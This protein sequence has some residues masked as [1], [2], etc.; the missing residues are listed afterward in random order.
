MATTRRGYSEARWS[1][2]PNVAGAVTRML[3]YA[4]LIFF[5]LV[6]L[7][8][9]FWVIASS[10][11]SNRELAIN[12]LGLPVSYQWDNY[13]DAWTRGRFGKYFLN[14]VIV[15]LPTVIGSVLLAALGG[16]GFARFRLRGGQ[17]LFYVFLLGLMVP[18]QSIMI[19]LF[20]ILRDLK[21]LGTY[22][23]FIIP[24]I[25]LGLPFGIFFMRAFFIR[26]PQELA[27]AAKIDGASELQVFWRIML[28]LATPGIT[29]LAVFSFMGAW[30]SFL[31]PL[32]Y[33]QRE[34]L[35][36]LVL[37]LMFFRGRFTTNIPLTMAGTM[38]V[39][40]PIVLVYILFQR[41][42]IQGMTAGAVKE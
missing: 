3:Q 16:Y 7:V 42:F 17:I 5:A 21:M 8:P 22:W 26:M 25:A 30:N 32:I 20:Y 40:L 41:K 12:T 28:P 24:S 27:E 15:S 38:I 14:S 1:V 36:P 33:M 10:L 18:F 35:R 37:G 29:S 9:F 4:V 23:A 31:L 39:M 11:K 2:S 6:C 19:P 13:A 34:E